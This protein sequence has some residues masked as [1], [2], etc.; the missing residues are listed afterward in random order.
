MV[1]SLV[2]GLGN[3]LRRDDAI[4]LRVADEVAQRLGE[5]AEV[6]VAQ[7]VCGGLR[8]MERM[9]GYDRVVVIDA[10]EF[11]EPPGTVRVLTPQELPTRNGGSAHDSD[12]PTALELGRHL[13]GA[14]PADRHIALVAVQTSDVQ[15]FDLCCSPAVERALPVATETVLSVL[16][17]LRGRP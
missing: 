12:L 5:D 1:R 13:G 2:L 8:L 16:Q 10:A 7:D 14:L 6:D 11:E 3:S 4:G 15:A 17:D 9:I